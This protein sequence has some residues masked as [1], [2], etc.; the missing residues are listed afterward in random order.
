MKQTQ[1]NTT[2]Q[3]LHVDLDENSY[4]IHI[5]QHLLSQAGQLI[6]PLLSLKKVI[7]VT[8]ENVATLHLKQLEASLTASQ[9][10]HTSIVVPAGEKTKC[11]A[12]LEQLI[13]QILATKP[14]RKL[15]IIAFGGGVIGDLAGFAASIILR[16]IPFIQIP[17]TLLSQV[18]SSVGGKTGINSNYGKNLIGSFYQPKLVLADM[19]L[20]HTL[21]DREY[22]AGYAEVV[23]YGVINN[24][25]F[26]DWLDNNIDKINAKDTATLSEAVRVSCQSKSDVVAQDEKESGIRALL[27]LGHTFGHALEAECHYDGSLIHGEAVAVGMVMAM[28]FSHVSGLCAK[29][30]VTKLEEH[31]KKAQLPTS[32]HDIKPSW[33]AKA[34][35][36]HMYQ[37][38][39]VANGKLVFILTRKIGEAFIA[40]DVEEADIYHFLQDIIKR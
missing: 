13:N 3:I 1:T 18:D 37:D 30:E 25:E 23:K 9:I 4:D 20:L 39:K 24:A 31:L 5:G 10:S 29:E 40:K 22:R 36:K 32:I 26:F 8:D 11:L 33:D 34:L 21:S 12:Q 14:E 7:I 28:Q 6:D 38:K 2:Q 15:T 19:N 17:T 35:L 16:G 27:N